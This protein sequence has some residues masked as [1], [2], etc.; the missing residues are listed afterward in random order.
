MLT[1]LSVVG[2]RPNF[3]KVAPLHRAF[4]ARAAH[5]RHL[6]CHTGQHY[7]EK[8]SKVFFEDL[9]LPQPDVYLGVGSGSH[10]EQ[11]ARVMVEFE[12]VLLDLRPDLVIVVGDVN[13]TLACS[14]TAAKL[15]V[16]VAHVEAGLRSFDRGMPEEINRL[17]TDVLSDHLFVTEEAGLRNLR[18][19]GVPEEKVHFVG[20]VMIDS[21]LH[22][23]AKAQSTTAL[24]DFGLTPRQYTL[25]TLHRPSNVDVRENLEKVLDIFEQLQGG[26]R[27]LF[28]VH[29]RT[30]SRIAAFGLQ[31]RFDAI[32]ALQLCDPIGYLDFLSLLDNAALVL[33]D[34]GGI[35]EETTSLGV[36]CI[37]LRENTERPVTV[38]IG[39]NLLL[40]M[41]VPAVVRAAREVFAGRAKRGASPPLWDGRA[42]E[43]IADIL[44][45][46]VKVRG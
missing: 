18:H 38:D 9:E 23:R 26:T 11:T 45:N 1:F 32:D 46:V 43:R 12:K 33:T 16:P 36:P 28:P 27:F 4:S 21:L 20:H 39:T 6:I 40:G 10:A 8:M 44:L 17:V 34:S 41:D 3:M 37:T 5:V 15:G 29:P 35:Q 30:R 22:Y 31:E 14:V 19:E 7:D 13:S 2:A 42:A 24:R 25:V